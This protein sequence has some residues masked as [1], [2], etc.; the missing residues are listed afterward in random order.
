[1]LLSVYELLQLFVRHAQISLNDL[2]SHHLFNLTLVIVILTH[3]ID[4]SKLSFTEFP[5][6]LVVVFRMAVLTF[7]NIKG[8]VDKTVNGLVRLKID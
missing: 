2:D 3:Q 5:Y 4:I 7:E 6:S 8:V 1:M